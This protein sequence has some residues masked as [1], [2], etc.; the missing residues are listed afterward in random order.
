M[1]ILVLDIETS[2]N[3]AHV[4]QLWGDQHIGLTQLMEPTTM[5]CWAA[6]WH[7]ED[8]VLFGAMWQKGGPAR[9]V[10]RL[11]A[12]LDDTDVVVHFNGKS[13]DVPH[14]NREVAQLGM[15]PPSPFK[16]VDLLH[17][18]RKNFKFP[19]N[20]L[21]HVAPALG[22][23]AKA[24]TGGH[25]L[26]VQVMAG[27]KEARATMERYNKQDVV[28][29][30]QLYVKLLPWLTGHP[31]RRLYDGDAGC[32]RCGSEH[33]QRRGFAYTGAGMFV[34]YQC[35]SCGTYHRSGKRTAGV[36]MQEAVIQ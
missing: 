13:F 20:K 2:P 6:K 15:W 23:E 8:E 7:G 14:I 29:T 17:A 32:P 18:V 33:I 22:C 26:W 21:A 31:N 19:S 9:M 3:L 30:D 11:H 10:R 24:E 28:V 4:W 27:N 35:M 36:T 5:L 34:K 16:Q 25:E 1:K 12:L